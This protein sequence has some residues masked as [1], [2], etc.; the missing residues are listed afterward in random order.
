MAATLAMPDV[1]GYRTEVAAD[2]SDAMTRRRLSASAVK[3]FLSMAEKWGL[4]DPDARQLLGGISAG[5]YYAWKKNPRDRV[6]DQDRLMRISLL[7]G[8]FKALNILYSQKLADAWIALP[9]ANPMFGG[10]TPLAY[11]I[12]RGQPGI[13]HV[14]QLLDS[15]RGG[16]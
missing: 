13:L 4:R 7:V 3:G 10:L 6:L 16:Q 1:P 2:L 5:S 15:R 14:R 8:V 12:Q 11:M 9:N